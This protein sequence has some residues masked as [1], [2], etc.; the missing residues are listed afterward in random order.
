VDK[1]SIKSEEDT[2]LSGYVKDPKSQETTPGIFV[3]AGDISDDFDKVDWQELLKDY[4]DMRNGGAVESTTVSILKY[5]ILRAGYTLT[6]ENKEFVDYIEWCFRNLRDSFGGKEGLQELLTHTFLA[7]EFGCSFFE[8]V[9][10]NGAYTPEGKITNIIKKLAP[11]KPET[12][13]DFYYTTDMEFGGIR[14]E[15]RE[16]NKINQLVNIPVEKLFFY[17]HNAE[18]GDPRGR[19]E[20]RPIR[21]L[22]KIK[23]DILLA[24]ARAQQRGAGIPEIKAN[25]SSITEELKAKMHTVGKTLGNMKSGYILTDDSITVTLHSLQIQGN[26]EQM[27][28]FINREMFF[29]TL[30]E[31]MASGIGQNG[32]RSATSE[33]KGSYE[34]K[35]GV[36]TQAVE[37]R[38][39]TLIEE[40]INI[41]YLGPQTEYPT[42]KFNALQQVD[43]VNAAASLSKF[44]ET[45]ILVKQEG[46][47]AFIRSLFNMPEKKLINGV[48]VVNPIN[49]PKVSNNVTNVNASVA[50][51]LLEY[52]KPVP[53]YM[54]MSF[55][56]KLTADESMEFIKTR[57]DV[58]ATGELY[59]HLQEESNRIIQEIVEKYLAYIV[60]QKVAGQEVTMKYDVELANR[61]NVLY[62]KGYGEGVAAFNKELDI[63]SNKK[64][65]VAIP[66]ADQLVVTSQS[67]KRYAGKLLFGIK[68]TV[69]DKI[70]TEWDPKK[71]TV[72]EFVTEQK[73][74]N[75]FK[76]DK[77]T[78]ITKTADGYLDG[79]G[80]TLNKNRDN[81]ELYFYNSIMDTSLCDNCAVLSGSVMTYEEAKSVDLLTG[82]G[83]VNVN[84]AG[85]LSHCRCN[86]MPYKLKGDFK[87]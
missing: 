59:L 86:L 39:N 62:R 75:G 31:F 4:S 22:Y 74:E 57:F 28:E 36:V 60:K 50:D 32:S 15:R 55:N 1:V 9:Y 10:Q 66:P 52:G 53:D 7:L 81:I 29:N 47:E 25:T 2:S 76:T 77:R 19:S 35:C 73:F 58:K 51:R 24:T 85:G 83:R 44:Y 70:D 12:I 63:A 87:I 41:S 8:K 84:C 23:K 20:L 69:E 82:R 38:I 48:E 45:A 68:T 43:I 6:Y 3:A 71:S 17:A 49:I 14:H 34:L 40:M 72:Q 33:H 27:L 78:L 26:P 80:D 79:R 16:S 21:N 37:T 64:L 18:F 67:L 56:K 65:T 46:D 11:F 30:T 42:F 61:L 13:W 54:S 5:P